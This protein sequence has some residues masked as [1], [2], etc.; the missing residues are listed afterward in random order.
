MVE[1]PFFAIHVSASDKAAPDFVGCTHSRNGVTIWGTKNRGSCQRQ[2][3]GGKSPMEDLILLFSLDDFFA[4]L[5]LFAGC[6]TSVSY[7]QNWCRPQRLPNGWRSSDTYEP[8][9]NRCLVETYPT[10]ARQPQRRLILRR[11]RY[12]DSDNDGSALLF[13]A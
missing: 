4:L 9:I 6:Y 10:A 8:S 11:L 1:R 5:A 7:I 12:A 3:K 13:P 2:S